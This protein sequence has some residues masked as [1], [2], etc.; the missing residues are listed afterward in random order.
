MDN[1]EARWYEQIRQI[2]WGRENLDEWLKICCAN[3]M[4]PSEFERLSELLLKDKLL[5]IY[6]VLITRYHQYFN[7][8]EK[9][10]DFFKEYIS[11]PVPAHDE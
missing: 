9:V 8:P 10:L 11:G 2:E 3:E 5:V 1:N 7:T 6:F 4:A